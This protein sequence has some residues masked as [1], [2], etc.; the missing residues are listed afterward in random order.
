[1]SL[2]LMT[3]AEVKASSDFHFRNFPPH[4]PVYSEPAYE[5]DEPAESGG[6][7]ELPAVS[8]A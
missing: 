5:P 7:G 8:H 4:T 6:I 3:D 2:P 1:M